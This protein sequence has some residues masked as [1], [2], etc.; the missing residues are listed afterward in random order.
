MRSIESEGD[1]IDDAIERAL[2][3]LQVRRD[4]VEVEILAD[5]T[6][7]LFGFGGK[8]ARVRASVRPPLMT[9]LESQDAGSGPSR[10]DS[11][12]TTLVPPDDGRPGSAHVQPRP[13]V[14]E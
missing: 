2:A 7:G 14:T 10:S 12:G 1:S 8:K 3:T 11:W 13:P 5:A 6:R 9:R 4:Q